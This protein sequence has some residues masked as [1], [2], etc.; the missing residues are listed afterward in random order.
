MRPSYCNIQFED[1]KWREFHWKFVKPLILALMPVCLSHLL[2]QEANKSNTPTFSPSLNRRKHG[3][4][5]FFLKHWAIWP[6]STAH[7][8]HHLVWS[9]GAYV[10]QNKRWVREQSCKRTVGPLGVGRV[11]K[12]SWTRRRSFPRTRGGGE[13]GQSQG[14]YSKAVIYSHSYGALDSS[15]NWTSNMLKRT[16]NCQVLA[17][18]ALWFSGVSLRGPQAHTPCVAS[19]GIRES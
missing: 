11:A 17:G 2:L 12:D 13:E 3:L 16:L 4:T 10:E 7:H 18:P 14:C 6:W 15:P 5:F 19:S 8:K 9:K 1:R